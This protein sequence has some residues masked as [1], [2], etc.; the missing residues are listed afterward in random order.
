[1]K[2]LGTSSASRVLVA[3]L[4]RRHELQVFDEHGVRIVRLIS[5]FSA[6]SVVVGQHLWASTLE[7]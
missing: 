4:I 2:R 1:M 5:F 3:D 6:A 7:T